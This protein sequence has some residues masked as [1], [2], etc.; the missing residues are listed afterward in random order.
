MSLS[1]LKTFLI[2]H[3]VEC[4]LG[5]LL[6]GLSFYNLG[7]A[8]FW[9]DESEVG[10]IANQIIRT[11]LPSVTYRDAV[12]PI[13]RSN[14]FYTSSSQHLYRWQTW[15]MFYVAALGIKI[16][17]A[18]AL[19]A[20]VPFVIIGLLTLPFFYKL[21]LQLTQSKPIAKLSILLLGSS[22]QYLIL[23]RYARYYSLV[24]FFGVFAT[25]SFLQLITKKSKVWNW[26]V[27]FI[28]SMVSLFYAHYL[29]FYGMLFGF[30]L[31]YIWSQIKRRKFSFTLLRTLL[32]HPFSV[33][34]IVM[35]VCTTPW[36]LIFR[37]GVSVDTHFIADDVVINM[38]RLFE[39]INR[40]VP[41]IL[42]L[43][44]LAVFTKYK[45]EEHAELNTSPIWLTVLLIAS[46]FT[47]VAI[48]TALNIPPS[49]TSELRY[50]L[51]VY[52]FFFIFLAMFLQALF[53]CHKRL[54]IIFAVLV[55]GTN[56]FSLPVEALVQDT[57]WPLVQNRFAV[58]S[59]LYEFITQELIHGYVGPTAGIL[60]L[61][62]ENKESGDA[63]FAS[64]E[65]T[66]IIF[67]QPDLKV[68]NEYTFAVRKN[69]SFSPENFRDFDWV[70]L[71]DGCSFDCIFKNSEDANT[72]KKILI[73]NFSRHE[74]PIYDYIV[75]NR[76]EIPYHLFKTP[77]QDPHVVVY[78][79]E[80]L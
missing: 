29:S 57:Y 49:F 24:M 66:S 6:F 32:I 39:K 16:G 15:L 47:V 23:I 7:S 1:S 68:D 53:V 76:E 36:I 48:T 35:I 44:G 17:G 4:I 72:A 71:R 9:H 10:T 43:T 31:Y 22:T 60:Q 50:I 19:A 77:T 64:L 3:K 79:N 8:K 25:Y 26:T 55:I 30:G 56:V 20:R 59:Y 2:T 38:L 45:T 18:T 40:S 69:K 73:D 78:K 74:I 12:L 33:A 65:G 5:V 37:K 41:L 58:R 21:A 46:S 42:S 67:D 13:A 27:L 51:P 70:I 61:L 52:P 62:D 63:V 54:V 28:F 34:V 75:D 14:D 11:G 80:H